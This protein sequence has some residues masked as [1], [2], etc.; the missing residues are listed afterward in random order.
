MA[1]RKG[2]GPDAQEYTGVVPDLPSQPRS[3]EPLDTARER[4]FRLGRKF[5]SAGQEV[6]P[7]CRTPATPRHAEVRRRRTS[8]IATS[9]GARLEAGGG[10]DLESARGAGAGAAQVGGRAARWCGACEDPEVDWVVWALLGDG[11]TGSW[12]RREPTPDPADFAREKTAIKSRSC[13]DDVES[14]LAQPRPFFLF[15][16]SHFLAVPSGRLRILTDPSLRRLCSL[17]GG[18]SSSS[19]PQGSGIWSW[20]ISALF[21]YQLKSELHLPR[22]E[23]LA[24]EFFLFN[25]FKYGRFPFRLKHIYH[26]MGRKVKLSYSL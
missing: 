6:P 20:D 7:L 16:P 15:L 21:R 13:G 25:T 3:R 11:D 10:A 26:Q 19:L 9:V 2:R 23:K 8:S 5:C 1:P 12:T 18:S 24:R 22:A 4:V 17:F 14:T